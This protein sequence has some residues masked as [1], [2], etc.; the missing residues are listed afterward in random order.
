MSE[1]TRLHVLYKDI[2]LSCNYIM[3]TLHIFIHSDPMLLQKHV[4]CL[5]VRVRLQ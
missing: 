1:P 4:Q 5:H 3:R 2:M